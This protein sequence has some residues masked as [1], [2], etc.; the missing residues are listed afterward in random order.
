MSLFFK[1]INLRLKFC[2]QSLNLNVCS[3]PSLTRNEVI[4]EK[5][6]LLSFILKH[7]S[8]IQRAQQFQ[9]YHA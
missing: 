4:I 3:K 1:F 2:A 8:K 5:I 7:P 9:N 6:V